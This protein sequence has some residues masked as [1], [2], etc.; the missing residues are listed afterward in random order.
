VLPVRAAELNFSAP[1]LVRGT[2]DAY[3]L[4]LNLNT[5]GDEINTLE[6][7]LKYPNE[8]FDLEEILTGD[9]IIHFWIKKPQAD[10]NL[11]YLAGSIP[12]GYL[13]T[14]GKILTLIFKPKTEITTLNLDIISDTKN[15]SRV[16]LNDPEATERIIP[17]NHYSFNL[18][19]GE[20]GQLITSIADKTKPEPFSIAISPSNTLPLN[21][22][23]VIFNTEDKG[24][25]IDHYEMTQT[26]STDDISNN[27]NLVWQKVESP[28]VINLAQAKHFLAIKAVDHSDNVEIAIADL[29]P[30]KN[31][32]ISQNPFT[33]LAIL[34]ILIMIISFFFYY[35]RKERK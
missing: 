14:Q 30:S 11:I 25:G 3:A 21:N 6:L 4:D 9:S 2:S 32:A 1:Q 22:V 27:Q 34:F 26:D 12:A 5:Q 23:F 13:G 8:T 28:V 17:A 19:A 18:S 35:K 33:V 7:Y 16:F 29:K 20:S 31:K 24:S 15:I 10:S